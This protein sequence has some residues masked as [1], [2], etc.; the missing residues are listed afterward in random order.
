MTLLIFSSAVQAIMALLASIVCR[1]LGYRLRPKE[2]LWLCGGYLVG[3][4]LVAVVNFGAGLAIGWVLIPWVLLGQFLT[5]SV[6]MTG[7]LFLFAR[8]QE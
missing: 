7:S 4:L 8:K 2:I 3:L 1:C 5:F 6:V